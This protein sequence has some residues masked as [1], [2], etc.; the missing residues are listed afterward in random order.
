[1]KTK[2]LT[3]LVLTLILIVGCQSDPIEESSLNKKSGESLSKKYS[4]DL[5]V[6]VIRAP[7]V[8]DGTSAAASTDIVLNFRDL[9]PNTDG[10]PIETGGSIEV[11]LPD[12]FTN[13]G[14]GTNIGIILQGW[15]Q[16]PPEPPP[17][18]FWT[19]NILGNTITITMLKDFLVGDFG[20]GPK[21][22][23]LALFG[24]TNP[25]PGMYPISLS[26]TPTEGGDTQSGTGYVHI[27]PKARP[28]VSAVSFSSGGGPPPF[29]NPIY[30]IVEQGD[31]A[32]QVQL[33][34]W[35]SR[36]KA[37]VGADI[38]MENLTHG[39]LVKSNGSIAGQVRISPPPGASVYSLNTLGPSTEGPAFLSG[40][41]VGK[42]ETIFTPDATVLGDYTIEIKMNNGNTQYLYVE[43]I[44]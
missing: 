14:S 7:I 40:V 29:N 37:L 24:F 26:I 39:R 5:S 35:E 41:P 3:L 33:Y 15:P 13:T 16:S 42:L 10:I 36:G 9:D 20:P 27:I 19:T 22:V 11:V 32:E 23:H 21:Q 1:M 6:E 31:D 30:Q 4:G 34:L 8:P 28:A 2:I 18:T 17:F 43:V 25:G 44:P 38:V 12:A